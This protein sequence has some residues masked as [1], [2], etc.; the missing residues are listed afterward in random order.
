MYCRA[1][2]RYAHRSE[3][4]QPDM[5]SQLLRLNACLLDAPVVP[6]PLPPQSARVSGRIL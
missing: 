4:D 6:V 1:G 3:T 5:L 2:A